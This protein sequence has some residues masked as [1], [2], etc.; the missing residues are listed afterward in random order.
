[1]PLSPRLADWLNEHG[2]DAVHASALGM[3]KA[4][5]S[6]ILAYAEREK[7]IVVT[8]DLDFSRL[9]A[10]AGAASPGIILF[11]GG[12]YS[13]REAK[14]RLQRALET[15]PQE[16]FGNAIVVIE[17]GRIRRRALPLQ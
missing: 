8:A 7:R 5:D 4:P 11:R 6:D 1:M 16:S 17:R 12:D 3:E 10:L 14:E 15:V 13:E 2:H 9:C